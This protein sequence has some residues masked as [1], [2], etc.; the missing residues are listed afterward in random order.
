MLS[1]WVLNYNISN[2]FF[3]ISCT[4][5]SIFTTSVPVYLP[6]KSYINN[7]VHISL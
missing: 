6:V 1:F 2:V 7:I 5:L 3:I 4:L